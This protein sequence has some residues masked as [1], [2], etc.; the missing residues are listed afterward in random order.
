MVGVLLVFVGNVF[1]ER[2][3]DN[4]TENENVSWE[5]EIKKW[6]Q[7]TEAWSKNRDSLHEQYFGDQYEDEGKYCN[8]DSGECWEEDVFDLIYTKNGQVMKF[9]KDGNDAE[10]TFFDKSSW[11]CINGGQVLTFN[12]T[13]GEYWNSGNEGQTIDYK[14]TQGDHWASS[15]TGQSITFEGANGEKWESSNNGQVVEYTDK[16]GNTW[17]GSDDDTIDD[18][19]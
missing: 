10:V 18:I 5:Q 9:E 14:N 8:E 1:A 4:K 2:S 17:S 7:I 11:E 12:S 3:W 19:D 13:T 16:N 6:D 15:N